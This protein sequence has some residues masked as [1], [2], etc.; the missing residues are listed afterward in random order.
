MMEG[1]L[2]LLSAKHDSTGS[3]KGI[4]RSVVWRLINI[5]TRYSSGGGQAVITFL[6]GGWRSEIR[7]WPPP[8]GLK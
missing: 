1:S 2:C 4:V 6:D 5:A 3:R 8:V 7:F